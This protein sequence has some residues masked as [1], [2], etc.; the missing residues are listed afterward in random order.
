VAIIIAMNAIK[1][2][3]RHSPDPMLS[4][5]RNAD[6]ARNWFGVIYAQ[7]CD[8]RRALGPNVAAVPMQGRHIDTVEGGERWHE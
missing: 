5:V 7:A 6:E 4:V 8:V 3:H 2:L 1:Q